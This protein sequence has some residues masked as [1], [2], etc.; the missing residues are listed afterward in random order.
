M[1]S[2]LA[3]KITKQNNHVF[4]TRIQDSTS[5]K[6]SRKGK[7]YTSSKFIKLPAQE[8][9]DVTTETESDSEFNQCHNNKKE[10]KSKLI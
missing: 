1:N 4:I 3:P 9:E 10:R 8:N 7:T 2:H 5:A 6:T